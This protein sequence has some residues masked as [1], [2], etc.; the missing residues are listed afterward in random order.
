[1]QHK[2]AAQLIDAVNGLTLLG[3]YPYPQEMQYAWK[4]IVSHAATPCKRIPCDNNF[5]WSDL[6]SHWNQ[7]FIDLKLLNSSNELLV[8]VGGFSGSG[9]WQK[10]KCNNPSAFLNISIVDY[11]PELIVMDVDCKRFIAITCEENEFLLFAAHKN[12]EHWVLMENH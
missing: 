11:E 6:V 12:N 3:E 5:L 4:T 9:V 8:S 1:M 2:S 7:L 10:V